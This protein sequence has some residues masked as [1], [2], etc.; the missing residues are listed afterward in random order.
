[1]VGTIE[2]VIRALNEAAMVQS[3]HTLT[4]L[5]VSHSKQVDF[6]LYNLMFC[7]ENSF[8]VPKKSAFF[9]V[10]KEVF[11]HS[12]EGGGEMSSMIS[13][14]ESLEFFK[15]KVLAHSVEARANGRSGVFDLPEVKTEHAL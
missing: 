1:M 9:S 13:R 14:E 11:E 7:D 8:S 2:I 15:S 4:P 3:I 5:G 6:C 10:M 12:F